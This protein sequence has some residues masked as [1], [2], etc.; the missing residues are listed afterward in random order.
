MLMCFNFEKFK[1][2]YIKI[3]EDK[4]TIKQYRIFS[5]PDRYLILGVHNKKLLEMEHSTSDFFVQNNGLRKY[6]KYEIFVF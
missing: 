3:F 4:E 1:I 5:N 2:Q 6:R